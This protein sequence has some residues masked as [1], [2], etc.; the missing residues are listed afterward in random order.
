MGY[1]LAIGRPDTANAPPVHPHPAPV[2]RARQLI[3]LR[4]SEPLSVK[5]LAKEVGLSH[6]HLTRLFHAAVGDTVIGYIHQRR[7]QRARHLLEHTTLPIKTIAAQVG[8]EDPRLFYKLIRAHLGWPPPGRF[9]TGLKH[10]VKARRICAG[11]FLSN[12]PDLDTKR[13]SV[14]FAIPCPRK[15][16]SPSS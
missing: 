5:D 16:R 14:S 8:V 12:C 10:G 15:K 1:P 11:P 2:E 13:C 6:N 9:G 4:L 7:V 3:E